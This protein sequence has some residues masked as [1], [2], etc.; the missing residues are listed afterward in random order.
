M[1]TKHGASILNFVSELP[2]VVYSPND[3]HLSPE[4]KGIKLTPEGELVSYE[5]G[6]VLSLNSAI[7]ISP[8]RIEVQQY[9]KSIECRDF[10]NELIEYISL[11]CSTQNINK[12]YL[13][14]PYQTIG[15]YEV[16]V[17]VQSKNSQNPKIAFQFLDLFWNRNEISSSTYHQTKTALLHK[18]N[19]KLIQIFT[20]DW[21]YKNDE[22]KKRIKEL[23]IPTRTSTIKIQPLSKYTS[24]ILINNLCETPFESDQ[25]YALYNNG[26]V[27][28]VF[29]FR[30]DKL[31]DIRLHSLNPTRDLG[32]IFEFLGELLLGS[33][34]E[35][36]NII[37][38]LRYGIPYHP[39]LNK[40]TQFTA[41]RE[42]EISQNQ[43]PWVK[44]LKIRSELPKKNI[45]IYSDIDPLM[46]SSYSQD[47]NGSRI[48]SASNI[49]DSGLIIQTK[50][51]S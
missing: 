11:I 1:G 47:L 27:S 20:D 48:E 31:Q 38:D 8:G 42:Y 21:V 44:T 24:D 37:S 34:I 46:H 4:E 13:V 35:Y 17:L 26:A 12:G 14:S 40:S 36:I 43:V 18:S 16:P 19:V 25:Q 41:P 3:V 32:Y 51:F 9:N 28:S 23:V 15:A 45:E 39:S 29:T 50:Y 10:D 2:R 5:Y 49:F 6:K 30:Y 33:G 22:T 7:A